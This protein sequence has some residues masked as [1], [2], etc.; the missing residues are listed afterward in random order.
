MVLALSLNT[1]VQGSFA[2]G[3][4]STYRKGIEYASEGRF[5]EAADWFQDNLKNNKSDSTSLSSLIVIKDLND[6]KITDVYAKSFF[7]RIE[8]STKR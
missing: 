7:Y 1:V 6:G 8:F 5:P 3:A 2:Q 4:D